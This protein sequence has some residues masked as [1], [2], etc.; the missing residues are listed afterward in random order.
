MEEIH[1]LISWHCM[2]QDFVKKIGVG[3]GLICPHLTKYIYSPLPFPQWFW[4]S[5]SKET[6]ACNKWP[7]YQHPPTVLKVSQEAFWAF[8]FN[9][10][11]AQNTR[12]TLNKVY[13]FLKL[14]VCRFQISH[15]F[16]WKATAEENRAC[17]LRNERLCEP[18]LLSRALWWTDPIFI[19]I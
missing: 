14:S 1:F 3:G 4:S 15:L 9:Q 17:Y 5:E 11:S 6:N 2:I 16:W 18:S 12:V 8:S 7:V 13:I 10:C 19:V